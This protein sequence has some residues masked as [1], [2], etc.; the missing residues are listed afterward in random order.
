[1]ERMPALTLVA[2]DLVAVLRQFRDR[3]VLDQASAL[4]LLR[5]IETAAR[6][7]ATPRQAHEAFVRVVRDTF[8]P[9][10]IEAHHDAE[11]PAVQILDGIARTLRAGRVT[12]DRASGEHRFVAGPDAQQALR[13]LLEGLVEEVDASLRHGRAPLDY[14]VR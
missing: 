7:A 6:T 10:V 9:A 14:V 13:D 11:V 2:D 8:A 4:Q 1:M 3:N 5:P 12:L